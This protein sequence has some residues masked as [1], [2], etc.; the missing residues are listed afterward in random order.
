MEDSK[1]LSSRLLCSTT[2]PIVLVTQ[3]RCLQLLFLSCSVSSSSPQVP[4]ILQDCPP[5]TE[6]RPGDAVCGL[7]ARLP[8]IV[9]DSSFSLFCLSLFLKNFLTHHFL[10]ITVL[11]TNLQSPPTLTVQRTQGL[12]SRAVSP[13][14][15]EAAAL[16]LNATSTTFFFSLTLNLMRAYSLYKTGASGWANVQKHTS[17]AQD[18]TVSWAPE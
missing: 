8:A 17:V 12:A 11:L 7:P 16:G 3:A 10:P 9:P 18:K 1:S 13:K 2:L 5:I 4:L 14:V 15:R 6:P